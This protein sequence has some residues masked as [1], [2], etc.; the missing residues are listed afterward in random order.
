[1][2]LPVGVGDGTPRRS[3]VV[4]LSAG[5][6]VVFYTDGLV[7]RRGEI[8]DQGLDR[9]CGLIPAGSAESTCAAVMSGMDV[10]SAHDDIAVLALRT[11]S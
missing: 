10:A 4:D 8:V 9:L 7:E 1:V 5:S 3:T 2:D 11:P 6:M